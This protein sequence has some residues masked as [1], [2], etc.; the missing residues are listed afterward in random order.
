VEDGLPESS[1]PLRLT[2]GWER[3]QQDIKSTRRVDKT[4]GVDS[5]FGETP[6]WGQRGGGLSAH[7]LFKKG[8]D[9]TAIKHHPR[10]DEG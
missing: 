4:R 1:P 7:G 6:A 8:E 3:K 5:Y 9:G 2:E 10:R